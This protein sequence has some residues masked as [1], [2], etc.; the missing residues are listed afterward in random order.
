MDQT[1]ID[2]FQKAAQYIGLTRDFMIIEND[3]VPAPMTCRIFRPIIIL[4]VEFAGSMS[5]NEMKTVAIHELTHIK[6]FDV[7]VFA[8]LSFI[9]AAFFLHIPVWFA[10]RRISHLAEICCDAEV[11]ENTQDH[12][13][14][15]DMLTRIAD[16]LPNHALTT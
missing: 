14:Y 11:V 4:P 8:F 16:H 6:R 3:Y 10:V 9:K 5:A 7:I 2:T 12:I 15:A 1:V 13:L